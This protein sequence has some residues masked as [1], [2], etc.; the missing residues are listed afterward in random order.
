MSLPPGQRA[1][2][3]FPRFGLPRYAPRFPAALDDRSISIDVD[4]AGQSDVDLAGSV[5]PRVVLRSDF[6]CV[7]TWSYLSASWGGVR[8]KDFYREHVEPL[9]LPESAIAGAVLYAQ[10]GYVTSLL[11]EDLLDDG[12]LIADELD[13]QPLS[14]EHGA[15]L[16]LIAPEHYGYKSLKCLKRI[17]FY[18]D[19]PVIKRGL[20]AFL[21]HPR[22]RVLEEERG[23]WIP[24]WILRYLY[25]PLITK[26]VNEF[27]DAMQARVDSEVTSRH[28]AKE[29]KQ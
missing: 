18:T 20:R 1:R 16:R 12:V 13:S 4:G 3:D 10:D 19:M 26:T 27:R 25:R 29:P 11:L 7:T 22:A 6:H 21:D 5:L 23:R 9:A 28:S 17:E 14:I 8:F 2:V 24:G 15:P